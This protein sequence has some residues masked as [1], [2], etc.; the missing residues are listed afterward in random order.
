LLAEDNLDNQA[1][2]TMHLEK[3]GADV[4]VVANGQE[5]VDIAMTE[6]FDL[7][8]MDMQMPVMGGIEAIKQLRALHCQTPITV[9]TANAMKEDVEQSEQAGANGFLT[10]PLDRKAFHDVLEK[11]LSPAYES[12]NTSSRESFIDGLDD[13]GDLIDNYLKQL[14]ETF[15]RI[16][17]Y[18]SALQWENVRDEIH[19]LK[20]TGGAFGFPEITNQCIDIENKLIAKEYDS[21]QTLIGQLEQFCATLLANNGQDSPPHQDRQLLST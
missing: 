6:H 10:K 11:Y 12:T 18:S 4:K 3:A 9:L 15:Q 2:I 8:L 21:A 20:G 16:E 17:Q 5:A 1:L 14:P 7:I 13:I 19:Q